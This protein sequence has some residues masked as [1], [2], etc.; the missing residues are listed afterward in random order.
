MVFFIGGGR[1]LISPCLCIFSQP[2]KTKVGN[3][4]WLACKLTF[5]S[6]PD[7]QGSDADIPVESF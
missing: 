7:V 3:I 1:G 2:N 6:L 5:F 4:V